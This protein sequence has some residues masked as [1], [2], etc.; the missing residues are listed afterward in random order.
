MNITGYTPPRTLNPDFFVL[1]RIVYDQYQCSSGYR[2]SST[3]LGWEMCI[4]S[5]ALFF[6]HPLRMSLVT[7]LGNYMIFIFLKLY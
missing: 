2:D 5:H 1:I 6:E 7:T 4:L 3:Y